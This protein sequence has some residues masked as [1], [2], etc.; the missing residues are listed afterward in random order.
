MGEGVKL[1]SH[2]LRDSEGASKEAVAVYKI[3]DL[4]QFVYVSP[5]FSYPDFPDNNAVKFKMEPLYKS[6]ADNGGRAGDMSVS[7]EPARKP[8]AEPRLPKGAAPPPGPSPL[9]NQ[10]YRELAP[11]F[12]DMLKDVRVRFTFE[13]YAPITSPLPLRNRK[14]RPTSVDIVNFSDKDTDQWGGPLLANEEVMLD[15][16]RWHLGSK[17]VAEQV[18][19]A[20][21]NQ[22]LPMF[23][24][25]GSGH[26]WWTGGSNLCFRPSRQLFDRHF[27]GKMLDP[28]E[29]RSS[30]PEQH[31]PA[32]FEEIGFEKK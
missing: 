17:A 6:Q 23:I 29:W 9:E 24:P 14:A 12:R 3:E 13:S 11:L 32:K 21:H 4:N 26:M 31:V 2:E 20:E 30:P 27:T 10:V 19:D 15:L 28:S 7:I 18:R 5:W 16:L 25:L 1:V 8:K 22:S